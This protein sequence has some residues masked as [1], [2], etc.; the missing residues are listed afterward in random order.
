MAKHE[1]DS[2]PNM[3]E[4]FGAVQSLLLNKR[5]IEGFLGELALLAAHIVEPPAS[6][7]ITVSHEGQPVTVASSDDRATRV[8]EVQYEADDGPCLDSVRTGE[9]VS[10]PDQQRDQRWGTYA[11]QAREQGVCSSLS[12]PLMVDGATAGAMNIYVFDRPYAFDRRRQ[13]AEVFAAQA[14]TALTLV[15]RQAADRET[16]QQL[17]TALTSRTAIDQ[18][19][20][21]LMAQQRCTADE[22]FDLL[23]R[24]SQNTNHKLRDVAT[25]LITRVSGQPPAEPRR[26]QHPTANTVAPD[27]SQD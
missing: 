7:G 18:A 15:M 20:G 19:L 1:T 2:P 16:S 22:A 5:S 17:E 13:Y 25:E 21:I 6:V 8:D 23:R 14:S 10:V 26:F 9:V 24:H 3:V 11:Q 27:D 12:L 4:T